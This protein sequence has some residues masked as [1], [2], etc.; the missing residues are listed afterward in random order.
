MNNAV[1]RKA[2]KN[3]RKHRDINLVTDEAKRNY[4]VSKPKYHTA[5]CFSENLLAL[6]MNTNTHE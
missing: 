6:E 5:K 1:F 3:I 2:M 4:L